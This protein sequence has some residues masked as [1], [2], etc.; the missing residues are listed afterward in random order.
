MCTVDTIHVSLPSIV[1]PYSIVCPVMKKQT[2]CQMRGSIDKEF[3]VLSE[4][5]SIPLREL[6]RENN[7][8]AYNIE[9]SIKSRAKLWEKIKDDWKEF[10]RRPR[11]EAVANCRLRTGHNC[12]AEIP[13]NI[14]HID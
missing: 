4:R 5:S 2:N 3:R 9:L 8:L 11:K 1:C 10:S 14:R 7:M 6:Y 13:Q 12:L